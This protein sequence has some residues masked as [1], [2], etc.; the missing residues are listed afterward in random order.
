MT[1]NQI[2]YWNLQES[3]RSNRAVE[4][5][6][7]R[8]NMAKEAETHRSNL[9]REAL[10]RQQLLTDIRNTVKQRQ[11]NYAVLSETN[12]SN[13]ARE[14][15]TNRSNQVQE[16]LK[17]EYQMQQRDYNNSNL[18]NVRRNTAIADY[19]AQ[20]QRL[21]LNEQIRHA[22]AS[23]QI[24]LL[25]NKENQRANLARETE[26]NRSNLAKEQ[27]SRSNQAMDYAKYQQGLAETKRSNIMNERIKV[28]QT[29]AKLT[30]DLAHVVVNAANAFGNL[31]SAVGGLR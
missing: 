21:A 25:T 3:K 26:T 23:E 5:E 22:Q 4:S 13:V 28:F 20:T 11:Y 15:E 9:E 1:N 18:L 10:A 2:Q 30:T 12:R 8:T 24:S 29:N 14:K 7:Q 19:N 6:T 17:S 27:I 16:R 31:S